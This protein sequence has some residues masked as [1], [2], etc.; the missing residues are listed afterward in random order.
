MSLART[1]PILPPKSPAPT[2]HAPRRIPQSQASVDEWKQR[3]VDGDT[4]DGCPTDILLRL[5]PIFKQERDTLVRSGDS[6]GAQTAEGR[7]TYVKQR[8]T[9]ALK[10]E[11]RDHMQASLRTRIEKACADYQELAKQIDGQ[12]AEMKRQ[13]AQQ[14]EELRA[15]HERELQEFDNSWTTPEKER[16][17]NRTSGSL[18]ELRRQAALLLK[19]HRFQESRKVDALADNLEKEEV[20]RGSLRMEADYGLQ[21]EILLALQRREADELR[22]KQQVREGE[23]EAAKKF[24]LGVAQRRIQNLENEKVGKSD[25]DKVWALYHRNDTGRRKLAQSLAVFPGKKR[26][27]VNDFNKL[28]LPPLRESMTARRAIET[29]NRTR[30]TVL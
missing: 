7:L 30:R 9:E 16:G 5:I 23:Y 26:I 21:V 10:V 20:I 12:E 17:Y 25:P 11:A 13:F 8:A 28:T 4:L 24:E 27:N 14:T 15:K 22:R 19:D 3:A 2:S 1:Q 29:A 6:F 18:K